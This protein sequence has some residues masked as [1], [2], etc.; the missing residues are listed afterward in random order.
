MSLMID[1]WMPSVGSSRMSSL[2]LGHQRA[3]DGELL[4]LAA[5]EIAAAPLQHVAQDREQLEDL[6]GIARWPRGS[7]REA[8]LEILPHGELR[9]YLAALR[10]VA[11]C[12]G[13]ARSAGRA[14]RN[15]AFP[16]DRGRSPIDAR[17][18]MARSSVVLPTPLRPSTQVT[19]RAWRVND[20]SRSAWLAP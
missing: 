15:P 8:G 11:R 3:G 19:G 6:V 5:G 1:G 13:R 16:V 12:R 2:R 14:V 4:L 9:K 10:H 7:R 20:T 17:P 18:T